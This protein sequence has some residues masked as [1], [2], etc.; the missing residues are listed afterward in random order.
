M[1][2]VIRQRPKFFFIVTRHTPLPIIVLEFLYQIVT[3]QRVG[4]DFSR[5]VF[6]FTRFRFGLARLAFDGELL[7]AARFLLG[8]LV[9]EVGTAEASGLGVSRRRRLRISVLSSET[10]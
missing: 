1:S 10:I 3:E 2:R 9:V 4:I 5:V 8:W 7:D 6:F